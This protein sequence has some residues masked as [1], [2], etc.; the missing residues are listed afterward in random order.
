[1]NSTNQFEMNY[2]S[3]LSGTDSNN[4]G[5]IDQYY[6][7]DGSGSF[8][9]KPLMEISAYDFTFLKLQKTTQIDSTSSNPP[10]ETDDNSKNSETSS[11]TPFMGYELLIIG[12]S[13]SIAFNKHKKS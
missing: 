1:M 9:D 6:I 10:D 3:D 4:D 5:Y 12:M 2:S 11:T 8:D 7:I 13:L